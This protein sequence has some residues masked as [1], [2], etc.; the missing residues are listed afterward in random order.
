MILINL[1][2]SF[3]HGHA[4][5]VSHVEGPMDLFL[6][7]ETNSFHS[8][9]SLRMIYSMSNYKMYYYPITDDVE[10]CQNIELLMLGPMVVQVKGN[11]RRHHYDENYL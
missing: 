4:F 9:M 1:I 11:K 8:L 5:S 10:L 3:E 6:K 7:R 2:N